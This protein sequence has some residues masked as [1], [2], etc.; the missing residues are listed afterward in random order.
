MRIVTGLAC[1]LLLLAGCAH[2]KPPP[3]R[4]PPPVKK[5]SPPTVITPDLTPV[6]RVEMV[7]REARFIVVSFPPGHLP[8][9]GEHWSVNHRG[10]KIGEVVISGPQREVDTVADVIAGEANVGDDVAPE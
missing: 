5:H 1:G 6:G 8:A 4:A 3:G 2:P 10:L 7:N 9:P